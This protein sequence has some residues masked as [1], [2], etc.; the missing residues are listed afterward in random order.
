MTYLCVVNERE[1]KKHR[2][3]QKKQKLQ[4][5]K[6][7]SYENAINQLLQRNHQRLPAPPYRRSKRNSGN[8]YQLQ[9]CHYPR[10]VRR[11]CMEHPA[12]QKNK[13][14]KKVYLKR[15][16]TIKTFFMKTSSSN[17]GFSTDMKQPTSAVIDIRG[18]IISAADVW[19][20]QRNKRTR[21]QRRFI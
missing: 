3:R 12:Q 6:K 17:T 9:S 20:I 8:R 19:N 11:R 13:G 14:T 7:L 16:L 1:S 10:F 15:S 4:N 21:V 2:K 18:R 5:H